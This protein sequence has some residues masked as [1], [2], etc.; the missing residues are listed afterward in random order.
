[1]LFLFLFRK[2]NFGRIH[3]QIHG[4]MQTYPFHLS[5]NNT[6]NA[7]GPTQNASGPT[8]NAIGPT[9]NA[10][11]PTQNRSGPT[12]KLCHLTFCKPCHLTFCKPFH[13]IIYRSKNI[14]PCPYQK[15]KKNIKIVQKNILGCFCRYI[16]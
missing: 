16:N 4:R 11:G 12:C 10:N 14:S 3:N 15:G 13:V 6:V 7:S 9:Q 1:M 2:M 5:P 8:Q